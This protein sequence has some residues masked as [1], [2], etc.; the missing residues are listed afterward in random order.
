MA[1][2]SST[3]EESR[4]TL[5]LLAALPVQPEATTSRVVLNNP[6]VR[7]VYFAFDT[8]EL[9]TDHSSPRAVVVHLITG[10]VRFTVDQVEH[11][12]VPGDVIYLAPGARHSLIADAPSHLS[13]VMVDTAPLTA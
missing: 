12:M 1:Q 11:A 6:L 8:G 3:V 4:A 2:K 10:A 9:L 5:A 13:L 7:V